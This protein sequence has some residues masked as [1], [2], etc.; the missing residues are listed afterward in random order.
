[1]IYNEFKGLKLS[2]LGMGCMRLPCVEGDG[3]KI[4]VAATKEMVAYA[5]EK[6]V[7]YFDTAW[8]Y[9]GGE[10][11]P[12]MGEIL[13]EYPRESFYLA[14]KFPGFDASVLERVEE[15]FEK[16]LERCRTEYFDFYLFH[17]VA[18]KNID[19]Y[20]DEKYGVFNYLI[21]QK[22]KGRIKHLG[23]SSHGS[24]YTI[25]RFL[26]TYGSDMEFC[27]LQINWLDWTFQKAKEKVELVSSYGIPVWVMEP[28]R[29][30]AIATLE[31]EHARR[32][33]ELRANVTAPE[34]AF[35]FVQ[36]IPEVVVTLSGMSNFD[37]LAQN[38]ATYA[39]SEPLNE[40]ELAVLAKIA[41]EIIAGKAVPC[42]ACR[43][44]VD[45]C[46]MSL[47]IPELIKRYNEGERADNGAISAQALDGIDTDKRPN[48]CI[49]CRSCEELCPQG[50]KIADVMTD[51]AEKCIII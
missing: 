34:W 8:M 20:T 36:S 19:G 44:C 9:H 38:I 33:S 17:N 37:Q 11:E 16:Q 21:E 26:D 35:R 29:G 50:I 31:P 3:K 46:P 18:E 22:R 47:D 39:T 6:G 43:Y 2:A 45:H 12:V 13:S 48:S 10:S 15:I 24:L 28:V 49:G 42:T 25:K 7:N 5:M 41:D 32:L 27:Q 51:F 14:S 40:R 1:M 30:G 4:D 23:F